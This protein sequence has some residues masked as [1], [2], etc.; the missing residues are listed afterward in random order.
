MSKE[1]LGNTNE[2][3]VLED[4]FIE[5]TA[6][7][8]KKQEEQNVKKNNKIKKWLSNLS[9]KKKIFII[10]FLII[11]LFA[12]SFVIF[13]CLKNDQKEEVSPQVEDVIVQKENY[14]YVNGSLIFLTDN[15]EEL[16]S[17]ECKNKDENLCFVSFYS[18]EDNFDTYKKIYDDNTE[19]LERTPI[20]NNN[21]VFINDDKTSNGIIKIYNIKEQKTLDETYLLVKK[22]ND[23]EQGFVLKDSLSNYGVV[24]IKEAGITTVIPF[25]YDYLG[26]VS[27]SDEY[28]VSKQD[29]R[30]II[31][32]DKGKN[33]SKN[34]PGNIKNLNK[35]YIKSIDEV[36]KYDV[37]DYNGKLIF[38][39]YDY[40]ELY[41]DYVALIKDNK[42]MLKFYDKAKIHEEE[43]DLFNNNYVKTSVYGKD[44]KLI[45]TKESFYVIENENK[46]NVSVIKENE[47]KETSLNRLEALKSRNLKY[48]NYFNGKLF[49]YKDL[50][51]TNLIGTYTCSNKNILTNENEELDN[52]YIAK[53]TVFETNDVELT[54][55]SSL[56]P[57]FNERYI[58]LI[59]N[60]DLVNEDNKTIVL[61]DL[62]DKKSISKYSA[63]N[64]YS[65]SNMDEVIFKTESNRQIVAKNKNGK[66]GVIKLEENNIKAHIP[67]K[68]TSIEKLGDYYS[69]NNGN[70]YTLLNKDS[71]VALFEETIPL[72]IRNYNDNYVTCMENNLYYIYSHDGKKINETGYKYIS[73]YN[74]FYA[75]VNN[76]NKLSLHLYQKP[77]ENFLDSEILLNLNNYYGN[78]MVAYK[79]D[80]SGLNYIV[81]VGTDASIYEIKASGTIPIGDEE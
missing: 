53:N 75:A 43:I 45:E 17:Y 74:A 19:I 38:S 49:I 6:L 40:V 1:D 59:D 2:I 47:I 18:K 34:I 57:I 63:V 39:D 28:Y 56:I 60:P 79:I 62:K 58:F 55:V 42:L 37:Y 41:D 65:Y 77:K 4:L 20:I 11:L 70:G 46:I 44:N 13:L 29:N 48:I 12:V 69:V 8:E 16:G 80:V 15:G 54:G 7:E 78:G 73:L 76:E 32:S 71:G 64:T 52:C 51:K 30:N 26:V 61:Y 22:A 9:K 36:G 10:S 27:L 14:K 67:F 21:F 81:K 23:K 33:L 66:Y 68:Y 25:Q 24:N 50:E 3:D 72:K 31:L 35:K 5:N